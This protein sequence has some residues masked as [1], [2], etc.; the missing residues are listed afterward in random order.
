ML[1][2]LEHMEELRQIKR[3][4]QRLPDGELQR[5]GWTLDGLPCTGVF[6]RRE[7]KKVTMIGWEDPGSE[8]G[9]LCLPP[10]TNFERLKFKRGDSVT[11]AESKQQHRRGEQL[12]KIGDGF[13]ADMRPS[14][15]REEAQLVI[16]LRGCWPDDAMS[17]RWRI[18]KGANSTLY[19]RQ[20]QAMLNLVTKERPRVSELLIT[21]KVGLADS[22][23]KQWRK[24]GMTEED[25]KSAMLAAEKAE[26]EELLK[27]KQVNPCA[28][29][30]KLNPGG[31]DSEKL[32]RALAEVKQL[33]Q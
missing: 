7:P 32:D 9:A 18:D 14:R 27:G 2:H 26:Q 25:K 1:M 16:R 21:A 15:G 11:I 20:L 6:G 5:L 24:G 4:T 19:E 23:S 8:M 29:L 12:E 13:I 17:R 28:K 3:R 22:W 33:T 31:A 10:S 30:A